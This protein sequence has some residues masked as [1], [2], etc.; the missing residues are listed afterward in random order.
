MKPKLLCKIILDG[1]MFAAMPV[2][3]AYMLVGETAHEWLGMGM[4]VLFW[5]HHLLNF[6]WYKN[7]FHGKY[8]IARTV[9]T[10]CDTV[11]FLLLL[12]LMYSGITLSRYIFQDMSFYRNEALART[13]H[14]FCSDWGFVCMSLHLGFHWEMFLG[15]VKK[16]LKSKWIWILARGI[17]VAIFFL[18]HLRIPKAKNRA[19]S[20]HENALCILRYHRTSGVAF[21]GLSCSCRNV[22]DRWLCYHANSQKNTKER[23]AIKSQYPKSKIQDKF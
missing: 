3:M 14:I 5:V 20:V 11:I 23:P 10:I 22:C 15:I 16:H 17:A 6:R 13:L 19:L 2:L 4:F 12:G 9:K 8:T 7:L 18:W 21:P 1:M